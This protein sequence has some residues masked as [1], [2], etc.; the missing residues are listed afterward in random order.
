MKSIARL[1]LLV[2]A[3]CVF[4]ASGCSGGA[5]PASTA[6]S[7]PMPASRAISSA[8]QR[9]L[10]IGNSLT[11]VND[12][13]AMVAALAAANGQ[14]AL[15]TKMVAFADFGLPDH[16]DQGPQGQA[17]AAIREGW[18][19][20]VMQQGPS[21]RPENRAIL[22]DY[23]E[24]FAEEIRAAGGRPALYAVWPAEENIADLHRASVAYAEAARAVNGLLMPVSDAWRLAWQRNPCLALYSDG[25]H[26]STAGTLLSALVIY[27]QLYGAVPSAVP[28]EVKLTDGQTLS[29]PAPAD[30]LAVL[31]AA[32]A[33][34]VSQANMSADGNLATTADYRPLVC[35]K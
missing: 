11:Y 27:Q 31:Q 6:T 9:V 18:D 1:N 2:L 34:A 19:V 26:A 4:A 33:E 35:A 17:R 10:F 3:A 23:A 32:A 12:L 21:S 8:P 29:F 22:V 25:L 16:W 30:E 15:T 7:A 20:V 5:A 28:S 14:P 13:P 24:R